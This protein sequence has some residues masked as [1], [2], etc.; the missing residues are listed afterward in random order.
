MSDVR[1]TGD[2]AFDRREVHRQFVEI[3]TVDYG[4]PIGGEEHPTPLAIEKAR[5][6]VLESC[7]TLMGIQRRVLRDRSGGVGV[8]Y[9][10]E[11]EADCGSAIATA[12][13][14]FWNDGDVSC[15]LLTLSRDHEE[16]FDVNGHDYGDVMR[17]IA[18]HVSVSSVTEETRPG[19]S[20]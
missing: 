15:S 2:P 8:V 7:E 12:S 3:E 9:F 5:R 14:T 10:S 19:S 18:D 1:S 11:Q 17:R 4:W 6:F 20:T 13:M 16:F